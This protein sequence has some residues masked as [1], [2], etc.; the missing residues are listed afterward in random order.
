[1]R[2]H[3][4]DTLYAMPG[5]YASVY[6]DTSRDIDDPDKAIELHRRHARSDLI[7]LGA[8]PATAEVSAAAVG[9]DA[10][11]PGRHG[12][13]LFATHGELVLTEELPQPPPVDR[14]GYALL[15]DAMPLALQHAPDIPYAAAVL[16][17]VKPANSHTA[18]E[19][20]HVELQTGRWPSSSVA[21]RALTHLHIPIDQWHQEARRLA[22]ELA[23]LVDVGHADTLVL[24]G[25]TW[26]RGVLVNRLPAPIRNRVATVPGNGQDIVETGRALLERQLAA[27]FRGRLSAHDRDRLETFAAQRARDRAGE[28][29]SAAVAALQRGQADALV[30]NHPVEQ[31]PPLWLGTDP[32][33]IALSADDLQTFGAIGYEQQPA[34]AALLYAA[35]TTG[36][37]L[38]VV[39]RHQTPLEDGIGVLLRH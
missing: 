28:G 32:D 30:V 4:L 34:D 29:L 33:Q 26:A 1:M 25:D 39:P 9:T 14:A 3:F 17:R 20:L 10:H 8:D 2:L 19:D 16:T 18:S 35:V 6:V 23:H 22:E 27:L 37:E 36:A 11:L 21:P 31:W 38:I 15:P 7:E 24:C 5:P 13:A 12:Q